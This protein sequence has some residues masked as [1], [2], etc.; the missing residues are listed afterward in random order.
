[1]FNGVELELISARHFW[2]MLH[3]HGFKTVGDERICV[4][5]VCR[6]SLSVVSTANENGNPNDFTEIFEVKPIEKILAQLGI[7]EDVP[8]PTKNFNY[9]DLSGSG[10]RILNKLVREIKNDDLQVTFSTHFL[11]LFPYSQS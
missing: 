1:M 9:D 7:T 6:H 10:I 3:K 4:T 2:R 11:N 8:T 5:N